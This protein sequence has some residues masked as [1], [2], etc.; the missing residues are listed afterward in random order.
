MRYFRS[1]F[2]FTIVFA[3][4][5]ICSL[6]QRY[7]EVTKSLFDI[8][9]NKNVAYLFFHEQKLDR[10]IAI[11]DEAHPHEVLIYAFNEPS[12]IKPIDNILQNSIKKERFLRFFRKRM[13]RVFGQKG[14]EEELNQI[15]SKLEIPKQNLEESYLSQDWDRLI[16]T[17]ARL[18]KG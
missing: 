3:P 13:G 15:C 12:L 1:L 14:F 5:E 10:Y 8:V 2:I 6:E 17:I 11:L 16:I 18:K 9:G 4:L 7:R